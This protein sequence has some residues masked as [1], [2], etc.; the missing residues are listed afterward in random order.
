MLAL[1]RLSFVRG[2][3]G[4]GLLQSGQGTLRAI[5]VGEGRTARRSALDGEIR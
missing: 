3:Y 5:G 2:V 1:L 4:F